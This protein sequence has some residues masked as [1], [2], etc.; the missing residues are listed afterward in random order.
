MPWFKSELTDDG[1][2]LKDKCQV[3]LMEAHLLM[4]KNA[5]DSVRFEWRVCMLLW[6]LLNLWNHYTYLQ[7]DRHY[8]RMDLHKGKLGRHNDNE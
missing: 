2:D 5:D 3:E 1:W 7:G 6:F 8:R 4:V